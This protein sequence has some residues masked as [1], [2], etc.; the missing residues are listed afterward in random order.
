MT[1][2]KTS[3]HI[4]PLAKKVLDYLQGI[5]DASTRDAFNDIGVNSGSFTRRVTELRDA[6]IHITDEW[7]THPTSGQRYK[8]Y[9]YKEHA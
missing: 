7:R 3:S 4:S 5:G 1:R 6:G 8:R 9:F 2:T